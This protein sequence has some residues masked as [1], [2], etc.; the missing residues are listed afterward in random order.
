M[1][2]GAAVWVCM[3]MF[4]GVGPNADGVGATEVAVVDLAA[5]LSGPDGHCGEG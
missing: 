3:L 2:A 5:P 4:P 1:P